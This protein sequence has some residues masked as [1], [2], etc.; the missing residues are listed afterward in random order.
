MVIKIKAGSN[1]QIPDTILM[2]CEELRE[3]YGFCNKNDDQGVFPFLKEKEMY[4][5]YQSLE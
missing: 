3:S 5:N 4:K 2:L 1:P